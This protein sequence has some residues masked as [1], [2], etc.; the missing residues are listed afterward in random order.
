MSEEM[1]LSDFSLGGEPLGEESV[2]TTQE[3]QEPAQ[4]VVTDEPNVE[5]ESAE[6]ESFDDAADIEASESFE[7]EVQS[8][9]N[10][11]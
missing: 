2:D 8:E 6:E 10:V 9:D 3:S 5:V 7:G 4:E 11:K 1:N